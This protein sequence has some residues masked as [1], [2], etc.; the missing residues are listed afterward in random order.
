MLELGRHPE[1]N[2]DDGSLAPRKFESLLRTLSQIFKW[3]FELGICG[4]C[5]AGAGESAVGN[6]RS[7]PLKRNL[8][9]PRTKSAGYLGLK[10][11]LWSMQTSIAKGNYLESISSGSIAALVS[12]ESPELKRSWREAKE[13]WLD[14][15]RGQEDPLVKVQ[16]SYSKDPWYWRSQDNE[17]SRRTMEGVEWS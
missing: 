14:V 9:F 8:C 16:P 6:R 4:F 1:S 3:Y 11:Q 13:L 2:V 5:L 10:S 17:I 12:M 15:M 7:A